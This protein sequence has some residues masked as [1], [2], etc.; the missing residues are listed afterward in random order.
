MKE[1]NSKKKKEFKELN[2]EE[3]KTLAEKELDEYFMFLAIEES[4]KANKVDSAFSV[5]AILILKNEK[6]IL[7]RGFS[8]EIKEI[9]MGNTHAEECCFIKFKSMKEF[10]ILKEKELAIF[11]TMEPCGKRLS[12]NK[13]CSEII[14][15][16]NVKR[17]VIGLREPDNFIKQTEGY[18]LLC[19]NN[20]I[21]DYLDGFEDLCM[22][23]NSHLKK[24]I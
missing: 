23:S 2:S 13:S 14:L 10:E 16:Y 11:S 3:V 20:I 22:E 21:V 15:Q 4:K 24:K 6:T 5:G 9:N 8:R 18:D 19:A 7:T 1:S 17:V 12:G